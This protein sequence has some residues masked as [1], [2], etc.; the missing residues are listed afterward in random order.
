[1]LPANYTF[2]VY[3]DKKP[4]F[5]ARLIDL[6]P[7]EFDSEADQQKFDYTDAY[8]F[9]WK[10]LNEVK[11]QEE[12]DIQEIEFRTVDDDSSIIVKP[13]KGADN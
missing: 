7:W 9:E 6:N 12:D 8:L 11:E 13:L 4:K 3:I 10:E 1:M 2:D 5:K